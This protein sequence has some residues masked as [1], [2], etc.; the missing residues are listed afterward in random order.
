MYTRST[1]DL[2]ETVTPHY[3]RRPVGAVSQHPVAGGGQLVPRNGDARPTSFRFGTVS[4]GIIGT[5]L[6]P[7]G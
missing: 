5:L 4:A 2:I 7:F 6:Q 3:D 1:G